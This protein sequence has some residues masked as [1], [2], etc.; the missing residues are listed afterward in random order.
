MGLGLGDEDVDD[1]EDNIWSNVQDEKNNIVN[2]LCIKPDLI[3]GYKE[4]YRFNKILL[5]DLVWFSLVLKICEGS[6]FFPT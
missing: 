2:R 3:Y 1:N 6:S 4:E 5:A